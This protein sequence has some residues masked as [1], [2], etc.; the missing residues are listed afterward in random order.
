MRACYSQRRK[1]KKSQ[2]RKGG[3]IVNGPTIVDRSPPGSA[4]TPLTNSRDTCVRNTM[5]RLCNVV[6]LLHCLCGG[7]DLSPLATMGM[8]LSP[9][10]TVQTRLN[11]S[12]VLHVCPKERLVRCQTS[13]CERRYTCGCSGA[14]S[15]ITVE[16]VTKYSLDDLLEPHI[17][18][19]FDS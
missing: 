14:C 15:I 5:R 7:W 18:I 6:T 10:A 16:F 17:R 19:P 12:T 13:S 3:A 4:L 2:S 8:D 11:G 9:E 1:S